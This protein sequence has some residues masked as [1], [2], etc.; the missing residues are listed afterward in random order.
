MVVGNSSSGLIEVPSF[1][2]P[3]INIGDRQKGRFMPDTVINCKCE[4]K[5]ILDAVLYAQSDEFRKKAEN[6]I[7]PYGVGNAAEKMI[8]IMKK[9]DFKSDGIIKKEFYD[10]E[11]KI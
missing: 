5:H 9:V 7:S 4:K 2:I 1:N 6:Y 10:L 11:F 3:T 8:S